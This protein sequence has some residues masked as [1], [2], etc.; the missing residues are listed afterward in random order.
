MTCGSCAD[1]VARL[2]L[3]AYHEPTLSDR[4]HGSGGR[5]RHTALREIANAWTGTAWF[6]EGDAAGCFGS[7]DHEIMIK[8]VSGEHPRSTC[9]AGPA[10]RKQFL[11]PEYTRGE[12]RACDPA[13]LELQ[14]L[15]VKAHRRGDRASARTLRRRMV[16]PPSADPE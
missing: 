14:Y 7:I 2:L 13:Y 10:C 9:T 1:Q 12:H 4:S 15:L 16:S 8:G 6:I 11:I 5:G 3:E